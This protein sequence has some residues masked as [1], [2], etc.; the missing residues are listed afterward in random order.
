MTGAYTFTD[1]R[2][3]GRTLPYVFLY[4]ATLPSGCQPNHTGGLSL[5]NL[6]VAFSR[7]DDWLEELNEKTKRWWGKMSSREIEVVE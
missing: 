2:S 1:Y 6:Y 7:K 3:Q 5:F 4:I